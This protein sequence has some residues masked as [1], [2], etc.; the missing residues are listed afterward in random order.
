MKTVQTRLS[1]VICLLGDMLVLCALSVKYIRWWEGA[2]DPSPCP[3]KTKRNTH[4]TGVLSGCVPPSAAK[5]QGC[6]YI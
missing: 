4:L 5:A 6:N 2:R 3:H 1:Q